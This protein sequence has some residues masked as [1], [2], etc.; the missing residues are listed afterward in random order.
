VNRFTAFALTVS[1][2]AV[3]CFAPPP[4][5]ASCSLFDDAPCV[6]SFCSVESADSCQPDVA[7][8]P[9]D[10]DEIAVHSV[11]AGVDVAEINLPGDAARFLRGCWKPPQGAAFDGMLMDLRFA[12]DR[13]GAMRSTPNIMFFSPDAPQDA[14]TLYG[15]TVREAIVR[16]SPLP[17]SASYGRAVKGRRLAVRFVVDRKTR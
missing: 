12:F 5:F 13:N 14:R 16:C 3:A 9:N 17:F 10:I 7:Y 1:I 2:A 11:T 15:L 8:K 4:E 6:P